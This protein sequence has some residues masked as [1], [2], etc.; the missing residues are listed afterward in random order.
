MPP[1]IHANVYRRLCC[2]HP[3]PECVRHRMAL[4]DDGRR[5]GSLWLRNRLPIAQPLCGYVESAWRL[6]DSLRRRR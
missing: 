2:L 4:A 3:S 1:R 5:S 6:H